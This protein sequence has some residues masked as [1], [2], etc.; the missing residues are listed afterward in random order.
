[1][2]VIG[3]VCI[4]CLEMCGTG[5]IYK[6]DCPIQRLIPIY[7]IV[8]GAVALWET[9]SGM[10]QSI[11][12]AKDPESNSEHNVFSGFCKI[13]ETLVGCFTIAWFIA[14]EY[15]LSL[16]LSRSVCLSVYICRTSRAE[17]LLQ[18]VRNLLSTSLRLFCT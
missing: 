12:Q 18:L 8:G 9:L 1:M 2:F 14:G 6:D 15:S 4:S 5:A 10:V 13:S 11:C 16:S 7:L 17:K 3:A